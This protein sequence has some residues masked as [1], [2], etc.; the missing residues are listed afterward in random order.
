MGQRDDQYWQP[1]EHHAQDGREQVWSPILSMV[2]G[3]A[4]VW[5]L[6]SPTVLS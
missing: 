4:G 6:L 3:A 1:R 2:I 5:L